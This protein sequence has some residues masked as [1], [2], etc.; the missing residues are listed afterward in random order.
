MRQLISKDAQIWNSSWNLLEELR[1]LNEDE[2]NACFTSMLHAFLTKYLKDGRSVL[3]NMP[4]KYLFQLFSKPTLA[5]TFLDSI[6]VCPEFHGDLVKSVLAAAFQIFELAY[7]KH[8]MIIISCCLAKLVDDHSD[9]VFLRLECLTLAGKMHN[10]IRPVM[11]ESLDTDLTWKLEAVQNLTISILHDSSVRVRRLV[12]RMLLQEYGNVMEEKELLDII[13][14]KIRDQ[15]DKVRLLAFQRLIKFP[16]EI[17]TANIQGHDWRPIFK[18][19]L[20]EERREICIIAE[21]LLVEYLTTDAI[22][23]SPSQRLKE[24]GFLESTKHDMYYKII[25][26]HINCIFE[27]ERAFIDVS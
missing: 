10:L 25:E 19:G 7:K 14:L 24:L 22:S 9:T 13:L 20:S 18:Q 5:R 17:L 23:M 4:M 21:A 1:Q 11:S 12:L 15:D 3:E 2:W 27:K 26:K 8:H 6:T 16:M